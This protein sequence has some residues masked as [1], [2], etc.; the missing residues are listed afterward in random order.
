MATSPRSR[1]LLASD[2]VARLRSEART[3]KFGS[4]DHRK[5]LLKASWRKM[6]W[7]YLSSDLYRLP[8]PLGEKHG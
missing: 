7:T 3:K 1:I 6:R 4:R 2:V 8:S 5:T